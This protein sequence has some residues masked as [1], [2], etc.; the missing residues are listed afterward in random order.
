MIKAIETEYKG[1][2]FRSR[3]EARWAVLFDQLDIRYEYEPTGFEMRN[4]TR[5]LPDFYLPDFD[6][7]GEVKPPREG[8]L[9]ELEKVSQFVTEDM[10][11]RV[12]ILGNIPLVEND[13]WF[14]VPLVYYSPFFK[15]SRVGWSVIGIYENEGK[16]FNGTR[17]DRLLECDFDIVSA[18]DW[19]EPCSSTDMKKAFWGALADEEYRIH[20]DIPVGITKEEFQREDK[21]L[22]QAFKTARAARFEYGETPEAD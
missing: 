3:L 13:S 15:R 10:S 12:L 14:H 6:L 4:K 17:A 21:R 2:K 16:L 19:F 9:K 22:A 7:Y 5:Y 11:K 1:Y 20:F 8:M 18:S